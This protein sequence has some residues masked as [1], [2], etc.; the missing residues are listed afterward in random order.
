MN[1]S[2][3][4]QRDEPAEPDEFASRLGLRAGLSSAAIVAVLLAIAVWQSGIIS[5]D[6]SS[7]AVIDPQDASG[8]SGAEKAGFITPPAH[9][10][11]QEVAWGVSANVLQNDYDR[12]GLATAH[13][14]ALLVD[15]NARPA[16]S[17]DSS[18]DS[19]DLSTPGSSHRQSTAVVLLDPETGTVRWYRLLSS[20]A[21]YSYARFADPSKQ[22]D[23]FAARSFLASPDG[24]YI[25]VRLVPRS[26]E[27]SARRG[28]DVID[29]SRT[30]VVLSAE[31]GEV[32]RTV[33]TDERVLGQAL[34]ND[35]LV[36][37]TSPT[38]HPDGGTMT[39]YSLT[40]PKADP[41]SWPAT[42][43]LV[44]ATANSAVTSP[45]K[46]SDYSSHCVP[47]TCS[48]ATLSLSDPGTGETRSTIDHVYRVYPNGWVERYTDYTD[49]ADA[50]GDPDASG[51]AQE[52]EAPRELL[53]LET[54]ARLS[55]TG[56]IVTRRT[57][58]TG[59]VWVLRTPDANESDDTSTPASWLP[60]SSE[61]GQALTTSTEPVDLITVS[62]F[63]RHNPSWIRRITLTMGAS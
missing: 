22:K 26:I 1:T 39:S 30:L 16:E 53:D 14:P 46:Y 25:V 41:F 2:A 21:A 57:A 58:L 61:K 20:E 7:S 29:Q 38:F 37:E 9:P 43:W 8:A 32:V 31:T 23:R 44:G 54:G 60:A 51:K 34:T 55:V 3:T 62:G 13:G 45:R 5:L 63:Y 27:E 56:M 33:E 52:G 19:V 48:P 35:A 11:D 59:D 36:V 50:A 6:A 47:S 15:A 10:D 12:E 28:D 18:S 49:R 42:G 24:E 4:A 17:Q 40:D